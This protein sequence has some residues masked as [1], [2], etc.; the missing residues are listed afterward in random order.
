MSKNLIQLYRDIQRV[1]ETE[2][3]LAIKQEILQLLNDQLKVN[4][5]GTVNIADV[6]GFESVESYLDHARQLIALSKK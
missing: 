1:K 2:Q 6:V 5:L 3:V 4:V